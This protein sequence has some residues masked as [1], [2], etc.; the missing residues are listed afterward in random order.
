MSNLPEGFLASLRTENP[1]LFDNL[2][3]AL[4]E[5]P[6][7]AVRINRAKGADAPCGAQVPWC[8]EGRYLAE[9][10]VFTLDPGL[11]QGLY[12][13]QDASSM[14]ISMV[15]R[16]LSQGSRP[17]RWLDACA[18]PGGKT[19]CVL[20]SLPPGS[21]VMASEIV[22]QRAA[23]LRE[24]VIK[25]G[26]P[27]VI[28][29][30]GDSRA[31]SRLRGRFDVVAAD[32]PC[33]GEGMMRK[34]TDAVS[35]WSRTLVAEC[36]AR[37]REIVADL[38]EAVAPGG[39]MVYSTCTFNRAENEDIVRYITDTL[40]G[41]TVTVEGV[42]PAWG[43]AECGGG[44]RF[45]PGRIRGEGLFMALLRKPGESAPWQPAPMPKAKPC[46]ASAW[47]A[48]PE[49]AVT[50]GADRINAFPAA[51]LPLLKAVGDTRG[52]D[53][54]LHGTV[55]ARVKGR[56]LI[57]DHS[58]ALSTALRREAFR[59]VDLPLSSAL[60]CLRGESITLPASTPRGHVLL[61][62]GGHPLC[63]AKHLGNRTNNLYPREWRIHL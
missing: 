15:A 9:R 4:S 23:V 56:D 61:T 1:G 19:T 13:V 20:G 5:A 44:Y 59:E 48:G 43:I 50:V 7:V 55:V 53:V 2:E 18:A 30:R 26:N 42:D 27:S 28:V 36:A 49:L 46:A 31:L 16:Q 51:H 58:L 12:Y 47:L 38:W 3:S 34:D 60:A 45:I 33:S 57:P 39:H 35:Q 25:W 24:N 40:G 54:I 8:P 11:H 14:F 32:V 52:L 10:P 62:Y 63:F 6:S 41:E 37:Q 29:T 22:P 21:L 17:L